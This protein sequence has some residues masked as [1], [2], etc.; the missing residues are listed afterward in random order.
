MYFDTFG[1]KKQLV[2]PHKWSEEQ[3]S[4]GVLFKGVSWLH[5]TLTWK[6]FQEMPMPEI[7]LHMSNFFL[8]LTY[9]LKPLCLQ[10]WGVKVEVP[11]VE[12]L[13]FC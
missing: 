1:N 4:K 11:C 2:L 10:Q 6:V 3:C 7:I 12:S 5:K 13:T 8:F 9:I